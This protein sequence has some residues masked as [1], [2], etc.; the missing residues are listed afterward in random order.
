MRGRT[1]AARCAWSYRRTAR[2]AFSTTL[3]VVVLYASF[4][5]KPTRRNK[6]CHVAGGI[7]C[8][9]FVFISVVLCR[10]RVRASE[11]GFKKNVC[12]CTLLSRFCFL[13][14]A[15]AWWSTNS[16]GCPDPVNNVTAMECCGP[17]IARVAAG[18][19]APHVFC[20]TAEMTVFSR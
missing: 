4:I 14:S 18:W 3:V 16:C 12:W 10:I 5:A 13:G 20:R 17:D 8:P 1:R 19:C 7:C 11:L 9:R 2:A 15:R 6:H